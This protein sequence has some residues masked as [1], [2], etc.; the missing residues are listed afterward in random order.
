MRLPISANSSSVVK[1][2]RWDPEKMQLS[3]LG[4]MPLTVFI[5]ATVGQ[6]PIYS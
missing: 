3:S 1:L 6:S 2:L 5:Q 4:V